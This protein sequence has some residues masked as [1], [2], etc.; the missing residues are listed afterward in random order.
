M[1][2]RLHL[3]GHLS[4]DDLERRYRQARNP[5]AR[6][7]YQIVWLV[8]Q[9]RLTSEIA[10]VTGY[11]PNWI[12]QLVRRYN[13]VGPDA[14]GDGRR[15]NPGAVPRLSPAQQAQLRA[16]LAE[17]PP[18]G[19]LWTSAKVASWIRAGTGRET[20]AQRGWDYL[21]KLGY[22]PQVPRPRHA[23]ADAAAQEAFKKSWQAA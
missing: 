21:R 18:D 5:V 15:H 2:K 1:P 9:G 22:T 10:A 14:L 23:K 13:A 20:A 17:P 3:Q 19:G 11:S 8:G 16:V 12:R 6:S 4:V 7:H